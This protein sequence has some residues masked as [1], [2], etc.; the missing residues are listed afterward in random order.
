MPK[1]QQQSNREKRKPKQDKPKKP[2]AAASFN[3]AAGAGFK[4][5]RGPRK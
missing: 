1:G 3:A 2:T 5:S 4:V